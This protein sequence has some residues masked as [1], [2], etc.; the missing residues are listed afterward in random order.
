MVSIFKNIKSKKWFYPVL[1]IL[2]ISII[3]ANIFFIVKKERSVATIED[4]TFVSVLN[5]V[6]NIGR[7][8]GWGNAE[9]SFE[10]KNVGKNLL[11]IKNITVACHCT[12]TFWDKKPVPPNH[13]TVIKVK[14]DSSILGFFQKKVLVNVNSQNSPVLLILRGEVY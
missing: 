2:L 7:I 13:S 14:Y 10:I 6:I 9:A 11:I 8:K 3:L 5:P 1:F 12:T 4:D